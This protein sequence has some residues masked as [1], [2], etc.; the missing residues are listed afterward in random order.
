MALIP[1]VA[2]PVGGPV[3]LPNEPVETAHA[4]VAVGI[5]EDGRPEEPDS[6]PIFL[7]D[8]FLMRIQDV[9]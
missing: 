2:K 9:G 5:A 8:E 4:E 7:R 3:P 1:V 6:V